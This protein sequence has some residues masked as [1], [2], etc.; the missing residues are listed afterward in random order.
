MAGSITLGWCGNADS[1]CSSQGRSVSRD[2]KVS[3]A[4][5]LT[6]LAAVLVWLP[7]TPGFWQ[8]RNL[9]LAEAHVSKVREALDV[10]S[11]FKDLEVAADPELDGSVSVSGILP[12]GTTVELKRLVEA[13]HPPRPVLWQVT[14]HPFQGER[15]VPGKRRPQ[16]KF[17]RP[18]AADPDRP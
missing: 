3:M 7:F 18:D 16:P 4:V 12:P 2:F 14:E 9:A 8:W 11:R 13:T 17:I 1:P 10:D 5:L 15:N 6:L